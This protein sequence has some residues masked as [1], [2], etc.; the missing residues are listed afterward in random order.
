MR[1][2]LTAGLVLLR[3]SF[4]RDYPLAVRDRWDNAGRFYSLLVELEHG[5][6]AQG[7]TVA[8]SVSIVADGKTDSSPA[9]LTLDAT[10]RRYG[11]D[12][13]GGDYCFQ[14]EAPA[15][16]YTLD[17]LRVAWARTEMTAVQWAPKRPEAPPSC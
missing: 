11:L 8:G 3:L 10:R 2:I 6:L 7:A 13:F 4:D 14:V 9:H 12:G 15:T 1:A 5:P 16:Q 17:H